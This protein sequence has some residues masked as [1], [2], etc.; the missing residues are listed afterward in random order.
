[1]KRGERGQRLPEERTQGLGTFLLEQGILYY[2][3]SCLVS[4]VFFSQGKDLQ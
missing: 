4:S 2:K 3:S 1:M